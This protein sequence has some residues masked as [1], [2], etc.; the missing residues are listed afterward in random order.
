MDLANR[1]RRAGK[2]DIASR[3]TS[4]MIDVFLPYPASWWLNTYEIPFITEA[5]YILSAENRQS[6]LIK[7]ARD[8]DTEASKNIDRNMSDAGTA[9]AL[10]AAASFY[11][12]GGYRSEAIGKLR[13]ALELDI[14]QNSPSAESKIE[15]ACHVFE[16]AASIDP[17]LSRRAITKASG[18]VETI[19]SFEERSEIYV[20]LARNAAMIHDFYL[21]RILAERAAIPENVLRGY[22]PIVDGILAEQDPKTWKT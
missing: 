10:V 3:I 19:P 16:L 12:V 18:L 4:G 17:Y 2:H 22:V 7:I 1:F 13:K 14:I 5:A 15:I 20:A 11:K 6:D 21:A 9:T 8:I